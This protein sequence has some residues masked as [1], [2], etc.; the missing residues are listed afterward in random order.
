MT[1]ATPWMNWGRPAAKE[2]VA[3]VAKAKSPP[4]AEAQK[5]LA[6]RGFELKQIGKAWWLFRNGQK[7]VGYSNLAALARE[8]R[9]NLKG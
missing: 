4:A 3:Y 1:D 7:V 6:R 8:E 9:L 5:A 2:P